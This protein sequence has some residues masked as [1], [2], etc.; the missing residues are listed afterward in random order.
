MDAEAQAGSRGPQFTSEAPCPTPGEPNTLE[1]NPRPPVERRVTR[2]RAGSRWFPG[3]PPAEAPGAPAGHLRRAPPGA[4]GRGSASAPPAPRP[5]R[6][7]LPSAGPARSR[8]AAPLPAQ[9][10]S[11]APS[12]ALL[13]EHPPRRSGAA[14]A[15]RP[16]PPLA[17]SG[18]ALCG[19]A[20]APERGRQPRWVR[21][22]IL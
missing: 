3:K 4:R 13:A 8:L 2:L 14:S 1:V 18:R 6:P 5:P 17:A 16:P 19:C 15:R 21:Q 10:Q 20:S 22:V 7:R 9:A 11:R 12:A